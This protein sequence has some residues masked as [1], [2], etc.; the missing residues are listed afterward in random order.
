[1]SDTR[2]LSITLPLRPELGQ[3]TV[4]RY[5]TNYRPHARSRDASRII[6][7]RSS[8][9]VPELSYR[10]LFYLQYVLFYLQY[11]VGPGSAS[12]DLRCSAL[13]G[14]DG[15]KPNFSCD[16][17]QWPSWRQE[18]N[19]SSLEKDAK[20]GLFATNIKPLLCFLYARYEAK[21]RRFRTFLRRRSRGRRIGRD[22]RK[23]LSIS[24]NVARAS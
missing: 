7:T 13:K 15:R 19:G 12:S 14:V 21:W 2:L 24:S 23:R 10:V 11:G 1:M 8:G 22:G 5:S 18:R 16:A 20:S 4:D 9:V 6:L 17:K 3:K